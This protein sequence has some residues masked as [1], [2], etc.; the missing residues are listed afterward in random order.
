MKYEAITTST[1][2]EPP[3]DIDA[4]KRLKQ[5]LRQAERW[6]RSKAF[7][8][9]V[10]LLLFVGIT[11]VMPIIEMLHRSVYDP[12]VADSL[13]RTVAALKQ[14]DRQ[15]LPEE[16]IYAVLAEE[17]V[18]LQEQHELSKVAGRLNSEYSGMRSLL[19]KSARRLS[20]KDT[21]TRLI[22][23]GSVRTAMI[24]IDQRWSDIAPWAAIKNLSSRYTLS[25]YLAAL[26]MRYDEN[27]EISAQPEQRQIYKTLLLKTFAISALITALCLILGYP[28]AHLLA[29]LPESRSNLLMI[30]VLLPFWT[31]LLVRTTSWIV[32]LQTEGVIN[33]VLIHLG[34]ISERLR[35]IHNMFG[36]VIAMTHILLPF[37]VLPLYSVMKNIS[38]SYMRAARS[39]GAKPGYAFIHIYLPQTLPGIGA[40]AILT[41]IL[42]IGFYITPALVGG[43]SGQ[44][45]SNFIA[46]HMQTSLNW[47]LAAALGGI[48]LAMVLLLYSV[49]NRLVGINNLKVG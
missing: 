31:S 16:A 14:W 22:D 36:T 13:P 21:I 30:M 41:F 7:L 44:M 10:P 34:L 9:V 23:T 37:M 24:D 35:M 4:R 27:G 19:S 43:R 47:G 49:Y 17:L 29:T 39:L 33:D 1:L 28:L 8:L 40:G 12:L 45:I 5:Q 46:Y 20:R 48:L 15:Q 38:P 11:F 3:L 6:N 25:Y 18:S 26:D 42:S 2:V 32:L